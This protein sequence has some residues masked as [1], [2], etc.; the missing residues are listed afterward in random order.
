[1]KF[2]GLE[3]DQ[4]SILLL[5]CASLPQERDSIELAT[6]ICKQIGSLPIA[7]LHAGKAI[8][9]GKCTLSDCLSAVERSLTR[10]QEFMGYGKAGKAKPAS[11]VA[12]EAP[13]PADEAVYATLRLA[14]PVVRE[15]ALQLLQLL[16]FMHS[17]QIP[18][19]ILLR[20]I[21]N[22]QRER[23]AFSSNKRGSAV[24]HIS[25]RRRSVDQMLRGLAR[26]TYGLLERLAEKAVLP[27][28]LRN[29]KNA[30]FKTAEFV[31]REKLAELRELA[32][33]DYNDANDTYSMRTSVRW[34]TQASMGYLDMVVWCQAASNVLSLAI[35]L[36]PAGIEDQ[37]ARLRRQAY[38]HV[39]EV[40][41]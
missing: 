37:D 14:I 33:I 26:Q 10:V 32:L 23:E 39:D 11:S 22:P 5:T 17:E 12:N 1:M 38:P 2:E 15:E 16:S 41:S 13:H 9:Q 30:D 25:S 6:R 40:R 20:A 21:T 28:V 7:I 18:F 4:S 3:E 31:L 36:P 27:N 34:C 35:S 24:A 8:L 29:L 19:Q